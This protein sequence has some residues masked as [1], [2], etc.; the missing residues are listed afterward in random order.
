MLRPSVIAHRGGRKWAPEN[1]MSAFKRS[2]EAHVDGVELDVQRC[3]SG[4]LVV[5]HDYDLL[6]TTN[7][8]G[9]VSYATLLE[10]KRLS[11]GSWFDERFSDQRIPELSEVLNLIDGKLTLNI[12]I[13][14]TPHEYPGIEDDVLAM[15]DGYIYREK[16]I[17]SSFDHRILQRL[18]T[19]TDMKLALLA[20]GIF[21]DLKAYCRKIGA[22]YWHPCFGSL[23]AQA[24][25]EAHEAGLIVNTWTLNDQRD[26]SNA[27]EMGI[28]GI[29]TDDPANLISF[30]ERECR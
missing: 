9:A 23:T 18:S 22:T 25:K 5:F 26:W 10:L 1:T 21:F 11:A 28:E 24:V 17:I 12:E 8:V 27:I 13:K 6:R 20:T 3:A 4:E 30:L 16:I 2:L 7:G 15:L 19:K 29:V 14:N